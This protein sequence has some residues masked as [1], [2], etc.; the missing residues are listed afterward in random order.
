MAQTLKD[1]D[2]TRKAVDGRVIS[3]ISAS[4]YFLKE[5]SANLEMSNLPA[6]QLFALTKLKLMLNISLGNS[7]YLAGVT[8]YLCYFVN[9]RHGSHV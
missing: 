7:S 8:N 6:L 2:W 4:Q 3:L 9:V 5:N 1:K